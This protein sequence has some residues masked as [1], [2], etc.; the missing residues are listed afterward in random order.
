MTTTLHITIEVGSRENLDHIS[1]TAFAFESNNTP[2]AIVANLAA[3]LRNLE[4][5]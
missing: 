5:G 4:K 3:A 2:E 1:R